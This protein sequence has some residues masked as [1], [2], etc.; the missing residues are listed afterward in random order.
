M[1]A[2]LAA[3]LLAAAATPA[4]ADAGFAASEEPLLEKAAAGGEEDALTLA[5]FY[6]ANRLWVEALARL[7][8]LEG[9]GAQ[10]LA[11]ECEFEMG[12]DAAVALRL[13]T[14]APNDPL[15]AMAFARLGAYDEARKVFGAA[16]EPGRGS[17]HAAEFLYAKAETLAATGAAIDA[18]KALD[19]AAAAETNQPR[20][21][22]LRAMIAASRGEPARAARLLKH[23][24][25]GDSEW[26]ARAHVAISFREQDP[27]ALEKLA[28]TR[29]GGAFERELRLAL[30]RVRL[31][32]DDFDRGF[33][34]L[35][36]VVDQFPQS[37]AALE[38]QDEIAAAL[39]K[40]FAENSGLHPKDAARL[41]FENVDFAPP[42]KEGDALIQQA[43][44]RLA[45][46][47]LTRQ[48]A[49]LLDHQV[50]KRLRGIERSRVAADLGELH[51]AAKAPAEALRVIRATRIA[52]LSQDVVSHRR[53]IEA[54]A[55][56][57]LGRE[58]DAV[59]IL[60]QSPATDD[61]LVRAE[62]NWKRKAWGPAATDYA[63][64]IASR[65]D[66]TERG[67]RLAAVRAAT[68]FLL[69]GDR[70]GYRAFAMEAA[71]R[72]DGEAEADLIRSLGDVDQSQFL[73]KVM[74]SYR[75]V[76]ADGGK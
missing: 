48:A 22:F 6:M 70:A 46:L 26:A 52:G 19:R 62:I 3:I 17:R 57:G 47:G 67:D 40:L 32:G 33:A 7:K 18:A 37:R 10:R 21:Y 49:M 5:R 9:E 59:L 35:N 66:L 73:A 53:Q 24:A 39:P 44:E 14:I 51:L 64:Y 13:E 16:D 72:M 65:A 20:F 34:A 12:R 2:R 4:L 25:S 11:A 45:A 23:A 31:G 76:Y 71:P 50:F 55:L 75:A 74:N 56:A 60:S 61:L 69:A 38:A 63:S 41:F 54:R 68:A 42:G 29:S 43:S 27:V 15:R 1:I 36:R 8:P 58:E 28:L 30:G